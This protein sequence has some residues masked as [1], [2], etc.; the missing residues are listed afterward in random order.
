[1]KVINKLILSAVAVVGFTVSSAFAQ[2]IIKPKTAIKDRSFAIIVDQETFS[3]CRLDLFAYQQAI[4]KEGLPTFIVSHNWTKPEQIKKEIQLL[5]RNS[6]LEG[7]VLIGDIP[8]PMIRK[9]QHLATAFKMDETLDQYDSSIPSDRFYDDFDLTFDFIEQDK[10]RPL[11]HY[12]NLGV[13]SN[14]KIQSD[15][16]SARIKPIV[17]S[18]KD[19]HQQIRHYLQKAIKAKQA[20]NDLDN[21]MAYLGDGTLSNSLS[22]WS[23]ELYRL[24]E[25]FPNVFKKNTQAQV[26]RFDTW[27][28]PKNEIINQLRRKELDVAFIHEHGMPDRMYISG[29]YP[30]HSA[31]DHFAAIQNSLMKQAQKQVKGETTVSKFFKNYEDKYHLNSSIIQNF[32]SAETKSKDSLRYAQQ[33]IDVTEVDAIRPNATFTI[34]DACYN[35]D[36]RENDYIAGR[37]IFSEGDAIVALANSVSI[38]Q[39]VN[40]P[41]L[42]GTLS[43]GLNIGRWA[44]YNNVL[45]SHIIG[46]PTYSFKQV[47]QESLLPFT[48]EN[49][50]AKLLQS[51]GKANNAEAKNLIL[52]QLYVNRYND[53]GKL[54]I[55]EYDQSSA[56]ITRFTCLH[57]ATLIG[58]DTQLQLLKKGSKDSD[59]FIRR[60]S[61]N[62]MA[63]VGDPSLIPSL[64]E[65]YIDNQH[66]SRVLFSV[67]MSLYSFNKDLIKNIAD[68]T[69]ANANFVDN[70]AKKQAFYDDQ[71]QGFYQDIDK[72]IFDTKSKYRK[73]GISSLKNVNYHPSISKYLELVRDSKENIDLRLNMLE[74]LAWFGNSYRKTEIENAC[75]ELMADTRHPKKLRDEARRTLNTIK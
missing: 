21:V 67:K 44:Q 6:K 48:K 47:S 70:Q 30:T 4:E 42:I 9:A 53:L 46:D 75:K 23:P 26:F 36:F 5:Y 71:F 13:T 35:G 62:I 56:S 61:I 27:E 64:I 15:I 54:L 12:Y 49:D 31:E 32:N 60:H 1:M 19:K 72:E 17:V 45:E 57:L 8:I 16:Y 24:E 3:K 65:A 43:M 14:N 74:S 28:F 11:L 68:Q 63:N 29:D 34:F 55:K 66:A 22:A 2:E 50:N 25:Q 73:L 39:D 58:G 41:H 37:F 59:E 20:K 40:T 52:T 33:G 69:F 38:L 18:G 10:K 51:L 7:L